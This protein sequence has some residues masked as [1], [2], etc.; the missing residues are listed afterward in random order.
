[1]M[2]ILE[3]ILAQVVEVGDNAE[4]IVKFRRYKSAYSVCIVCIVHDLPLH[5]YTPVYTPILS[6]YPL[7]TPYPPTHP[8]HPYTPLYTPIYT[9][10]T[11]N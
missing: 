4:E 9:L 1:M 11:E 5:P 8:I 6:I 7:Y 3:K 10:Y 2:M